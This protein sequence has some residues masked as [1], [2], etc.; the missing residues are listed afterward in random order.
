[1][2]PPRSWT[3][4][5]LFERNKRAGLGYEGDIITAH[6]SNAAGASLIRV[7]YPPDLF[8]RYWRLSRGKVYKS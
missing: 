2:F 1:M 5:R 7:N 6:V 4:W 8:L 3:R